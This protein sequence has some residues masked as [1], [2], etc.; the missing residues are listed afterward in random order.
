VP[1]N[2]D[3]TNSELCVRL[4]MGCGAHIGVTMASIR[5]SRI[6]QHQSAIDDGAHTRWSPRERIR[7]RPTHCSRRA[8]PWH[9]CWPSIPSVLSP[10]PAPRPPP[11]AR[12]AGGRQ[13]S[14]SK[15]S[16]RL[17]SLVPVDLLA[18]WMKT[19]PRPM[20]GAVHDD[21]PHAAGAHLPACASPKMLCAISPP[22][23]SARASVRRRGDLHQRAVDKRPS[24]LEHPHH[25]P[26]H[27]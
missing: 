19:E 17:R 6:V 22:W 24:G 8:Q 26:G 18:Q 11:R 27:P 13:V 20:C 16:I 2:I 14:M 9:R 12:S 25:S 21:A 23:P 7:D 1:W 3:A 4:D 10:A 5:V 15:F